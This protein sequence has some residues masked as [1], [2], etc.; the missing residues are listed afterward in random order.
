MTTIRKFYYTKEF[1]QTK[2]GKEFSAKRAASRKAYNKTPEGIE[3]LDKLK[4][5]LNKFY[6]TEEGKK[7]I[8]KRAASKKAYDKTPEGIESRIKAGIK[9]RRIVCQ[10]SKDGNFIAEFPSI[11]EATN[12]T[13]IKSISA[14]LRGIRNHAKGFIWKYK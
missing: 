1:Y 13:G 12:V 7:S 4:D 8:T 9:H 2:E 10:F 6:Q 3:K 11:T 5:K 14:C